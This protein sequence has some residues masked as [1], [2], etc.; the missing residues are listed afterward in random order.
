MCIRDR[1][2]RERERESSDFIAKLFENT[3]D[4]HSK[5]HA[6]K[7]PRAVTRVADNLIEDACAGMVILYF[8]REQ[9]PQT[10]NDNVSSCPA[11]NS[12]F[13]F[14]AELLSFPPVSWVNPFLHRVLFYCALF[15]AK[16]KKNHGSVLEEVGGNA[17]CANKV[18]D[19]RLFYLPKQLNSCLLGC[20]V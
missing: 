5:L 16:N 3:R 15:E 14:C 1:R 8:R 10:S 17:V 7:L 19:S 4:P 9:P 13:F 12:F 6:D 11:S 2:E 18:Q 20:T